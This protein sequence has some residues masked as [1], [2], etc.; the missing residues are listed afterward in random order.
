MTTK[1][2]LPNGAHIAYKLNKL[3]NNQINSYEYHPSCETECENEFVNNME[4][5]LTIDLL[6]CLGVH[7]KKE[8]IIDFEKKNIDNIEFANRIAS[9]EKEG[10]Y[11]G[12]THYPFAVHVV[13]VSNYS[14]HLDIVSDVFLNSTNFHVLQTQKGFNTWRGIAV[15]VLGSKLDLNNIIKETVEKCYL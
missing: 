8:D 13:L 7:V 6:P 14:S 3:I 2:L 4:K 9:Y 12:K 5:S 15:P 11:P 10:R 1:E